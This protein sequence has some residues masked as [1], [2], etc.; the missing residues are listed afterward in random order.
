M[1]R[2]T[3][4]YGACA[5]VAASSVGT[6]AR[7]G[8]RI[9]VGV[10][11]PF[12]GVQAEVANDLRSGYEM[13]FAQAG[14]VGLEI[15]PV[16]ADDQAKPDQTALLV[17]SFARDASFVATTGIVGTPHA[18][19][20]LPLAARGALPVVGLRSGAI[21]LR[22][23]TPGIYHLRA[24]F[25]DELT[26]ISRVISGSGSGRLAIVYSD[27]AFGQASVAHV[28]KIAASVGL[29]I[30]S[31][32][33]A[34]RSGSNIV[35]SV[36]QALQPNLKAAALL[37]L[38]L[39]GPMIRAT[40]H[41]RQKLSFIA[42]VYCMSFCATRRLA[43]SD[44]PSL[45][46]L[47]LMSAFPLPRTDLSPL[48]RGFRTVA[49]DWHRGGVI[50]SLTTFEGFLYGSVLVRGLQRAPEP[51]RRGLVAAMTTPQDVGGIRVAF[52]DKLVGYRYLQL[53]YKSR[54]GILRA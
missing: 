17:D 33:A 10:P 47:G 16:W 41:A 50:N 29:S 43:E 51:T 20:A 39:E 37:L 3:L 19:A 24:S 7:A 42:P 27:D 6:L 30:V 2:R 48:A 31:K 40:L 14:R 35:Q 1:K 22:D 13:A 23:G 54:T 49:A 45:V 9:R 25:T 38:V 11:L 12:T 34:E 15:E 4:L 53:I 5:A 44:D 21:E 28:E 36:T 8:S 18:K 52:D 32:V 26:A 46:G